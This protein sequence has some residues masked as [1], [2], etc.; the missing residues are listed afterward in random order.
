MT[1]DQDR[2]AHLMGMDTDAWENFVDLWFPS[3]SQRERRK[4][5]ELLYLLCRK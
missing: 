5:A 1:T 3:L 4:F 2:L